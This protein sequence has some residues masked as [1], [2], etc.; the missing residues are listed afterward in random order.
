MLSCK[1]GYIEIAEILLDNKAN[2][3]E[4]NILGDTSLKLAQKHGHENLVIILIQKYKA[5][6]RQSAKPVRNNNKI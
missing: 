1:L 2:L 3:Y 6:A 5:L 4:I